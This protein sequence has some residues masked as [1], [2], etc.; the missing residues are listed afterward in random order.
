MVS[1]G[2]HRMIATVC[3]RLFACG[4]RNNE[5]ATPMDPSVLHCCTLKV[6]LCRRSSSPSAATFK[7]TPAGTSRNSQRPTPTMPKKAHEYG[8]IVFVAA[9]VSS[10][11]RKAAVQPHEL[12]YATSH[13][14][15]A[16]PRKDWPDW[17]ATWASECKCPWP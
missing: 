12:A 6:R 17:A 9:L 7:R 11:L 14:R 4:N 5:V 16:H 3:A 15:A 2:L 13:G 1:N 8:M 10:T